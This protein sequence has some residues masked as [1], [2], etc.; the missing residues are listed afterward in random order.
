MDSPRADDVQARA[1]LS[2][3]ECEQRTCD[4]AY[5]LRRHASQMAEALDLVKRGLSEEE[6]QEVVA[7]ARVSFIEAQAAWDAYREHLIE[8]GLNLRQST[9]P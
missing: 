4:A 1:C 9:Q 7:K 2:C 3:P 8:H 5:T 6:R